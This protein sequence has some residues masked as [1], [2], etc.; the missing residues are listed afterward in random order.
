MSAL[1]A[2]CV[3]AW[4]GASGSLRLTDCPASCYLPSC[5]NTTFGVCADGPEIAVTIKQGNREVTAYRDGESS[6]SV[7]QLGVHIYPCY[8]A[9]W[10]SVS[11]CSDLCGFCL[12][13]L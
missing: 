9:T 5:P 1:F 12:Q 8:P 3:I 4:I 6:S 2:A 11:S 13:T 7:Q 10:S